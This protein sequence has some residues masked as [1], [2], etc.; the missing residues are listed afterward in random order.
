MSRLDDLLGGLLGGQGGTGSPSVAASGQGPE[1]SGR[2]EAP[3]SSTA[4][5]GPENVSQLW[6]PV[7]SMPRTNQV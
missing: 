1:G 3:P 6:G 2:A 4:Y 5:T 7:P